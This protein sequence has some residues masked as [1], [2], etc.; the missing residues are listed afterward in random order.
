MR[1]ISPVSRSVL[2]A[3]LAASGVS[4][5][6]HVIDSPAEP[7]PV[8]PVIA[9][10]AD[11]ATYRGIVDSIDEATQ[12]YQVAIL[13]PGLTQESCRTAWTLYDSIATSD[14]GQMIGL[15]DEMEAFMDAH[16]GAFVADMVCVPRLMMAELDQHSNVACM[17]STQKSNRAE[18][19]RHAAVMSEFIGH[20]G[21]RVDEM[22]GGSGSWH[23]PMCN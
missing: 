2:V 21:A 3:V 8:A 10:D 9:T 14:V 20:V 6:D 13:D 18:S 11:I 17:W 4:A 15:G 1:C 12:N 22:A 16:D 7:E 5:C 19:L 23:D